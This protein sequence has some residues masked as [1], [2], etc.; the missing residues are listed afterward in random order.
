MVSLPSDMRR[1]IDIFLR[2]VNIRLTRKQC[3]G[4]P[5]AAIP[6]FSPHMLVGKFPKPFLTQ[7]RGLV[8]GPARAV[9]LPLNR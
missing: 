5:R 7:L 1:L 6:A 4:A 9:H 2:I 8:H 3:P